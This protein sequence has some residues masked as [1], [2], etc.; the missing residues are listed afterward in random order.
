M[1]TRMLFAAA[2]AALLLPGTAGAVDRLEYATP[3]GETLVR[4]IVAVS[5]ED[6]KQFR[7]RAMIGGRKRRLDLATRYILSFRRGSRDDIN[8]WSKKLA[9][10]Y[11]LI[12]TGQL[13]TKENVPGAEEVLQAITFSTEKGTR[14]QERTEAV[15]AWQT[16]YALFYLIDVRYEIGIRDDNKDKLQ[17]ALQD[18][19]QFRRRTEA[20]RTLKWDVPGDAGTK[21]TKIWAWGSTWLWPQVLLHKARI[22]RALGDA[23]GAAATFDQVADMAK[24]EELSPHLIAEAVI[25]KATMEAA[26]KDSGAAE[27]IYR[28]AGNKLRSGIG[29]Q[30][31]AYGKRVLRQAA[32]L[33]LLKGADLLLASAAAKQVSYDV[34]LKRYQALASAEGRTDPALYAGAQAGIGICEVEQGAGGKAYKTLLWV[35]VNGYAYPEQVQRA[36]YYL[37]KAAPLFAKEIEAQGGD[38]ATLRR[39]GERWQD[40]LK[41]RFP[42]SPWA[43]K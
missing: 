33:A 28:S 21:E 20:K 30:P 10:A 39:A 25:E 17:Q 42:D 37:G 11:R 13:A 31:D 14:G 3:G 43:K 34:P 16:M 6:L 1:R 5:R 29:S 7:V 23:A 2:A 18:V 38:G 36:L 24:K 27:Q 4:S 40:D 9:N 12:S 32:N 19:D 41:Q 26:G 8:Q 22:Q 35:V 15:Q